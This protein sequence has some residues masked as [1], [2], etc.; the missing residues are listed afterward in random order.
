MKTTSMPSPSALLA[1]STPGVSAI[2]D[3]RFLPFCECHRWRV[4]PTKGYVFTSIGDE[5]RTLY[6]HRLITALTEGLSEVDGCDVHHT[7]GNKLDNRQDALILLTP[8]EHSR[9]TYSKSPIY[10]GMGTQRTSSG[11]WRAYITIQGKSR[12]LGT[13]P[14]QDEA[15]TAYLAARY[16]EGIPD[17]ELPNNRPD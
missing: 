1:T 9:L 10:F 17:N 14:T 4:H 8:Q 12:H 6:L 7:G 2:I 15:F 5:Y 11:K 16:P 13:F 3:A